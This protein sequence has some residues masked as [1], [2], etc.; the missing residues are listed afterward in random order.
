VKVVAVA[1][2]VPVRAEGSRGRDLNRHT[3]Y[4]SSPARAG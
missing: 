2:I 4:D 1:L 3:S